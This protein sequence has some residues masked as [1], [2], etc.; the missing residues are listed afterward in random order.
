[1]FWL[2]VVVLLAIGAHLPTGC[3]G[4]AAAEAQAGAVVACTLSLIVVATN[5]TFV[6]YSVPSRDRH[7]RGG[8]RRCGRRAALSAFAARAYFG[9][10]ALLALGYLTRYNNIVLL[11][12]LMLLAGPKCHGDSSP[13]S[14]GP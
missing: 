13:P 6:D 4:D 3:G 9:S 10:G 12:A 5:P 2:P 1:M 8:P 14:R 11:P 7:V